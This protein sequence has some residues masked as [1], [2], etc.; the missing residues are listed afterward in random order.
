MNSAWQLPAEA[1]V[2]IRTTAAAL[3]SYAVALALGL[4]QAVWAV[5]TALVVMQASVGA[6][7][8]ASIDRMAGTLGGAVV[9]GIVATAQPRLGL[10]DWAALAVAVAP[11]SALASVSPRLRIA[12]LT[13][14]IILLAIPSEIAAPVAAVERIVEIGLGTVVGLAAAENSGAELMR[15]RAAHVTDAA[16]RSPILRSLRR[17]R[18]DVALLSRTLPEASARAF[19][20]ASRTR[21]RRPGGGPGRHA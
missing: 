13:S 19:G 21:H 9:G 3:A 5:V 18:S 17:L 6:T 10:P 4:P 8:G 14:A 2:A 12:P 16:D 20:V 7:I 11:L 15:E 1:K